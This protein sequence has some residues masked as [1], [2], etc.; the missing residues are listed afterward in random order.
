VY[1][2]AVACE[3]VAAS[4]GADWA[5]LNALLDIAVPA[6]GEALF[7]TAA[8]A[9]AVPVLAPLVVVVEPELPALRVW[10]MEINCSRLFTCTNWLMYSLGSVFAVGS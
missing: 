5:G 2:I 6:A 4:T 8:D 3:P 10:L 7:N 9:A 1:W